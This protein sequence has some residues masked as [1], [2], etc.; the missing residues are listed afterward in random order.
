MKNFF[1]CISVDI[2]TMS[3]RIP[4]YVASEKGDVV[5]HNIYMYVIYK[6]VYIE[7]LCKICK[8]VPKREG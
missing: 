6:Y 4:Y 8:F 7:S 1:E 3:E 5:V 2:N